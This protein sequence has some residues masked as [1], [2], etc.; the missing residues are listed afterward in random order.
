MNIADEQLRTHVM[1]DAIIIS[2]NFTTTIQ[3]T[4]DA[5]NFALR[6]VISQD[7]KPISFASRTLGDY[8]QNYSIMI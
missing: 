2:P 5:S 8:E 1:S 3:A 4:T 7:H 6:A